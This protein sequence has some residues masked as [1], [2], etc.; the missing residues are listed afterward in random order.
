MLQMLHNVIKG[1]AEMIITILY[2]SVKLRLFN[3]E[4]ARVENLTADTMRRMQDTTEE[5]RKAREENKGLRLELLKAES[6]LMKQKIEMKY[7]ESERDSAERKLTQ[8]SAPSDEICEASLAIRVNVRDLSLV[9]LSL[10]AAR[11]H[12]SLGSS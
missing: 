6:E 11:S 9:G 3:D 2:L 5:L 4:I 8:T 10:R 12:R 7:I 1:Y